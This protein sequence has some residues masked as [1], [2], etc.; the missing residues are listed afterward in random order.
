MQCIVAKF[1]IILSFKGARC[2]LTDVPRLDTPLSPLPSFD[3][4][5]KALM[6]SAR[7]HGHVVLVFYCPMVCLSSARRGHHFK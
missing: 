1:P 6:K 2:T 4:L 7:V 3:I 5:P